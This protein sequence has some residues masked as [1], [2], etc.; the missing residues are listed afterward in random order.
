MAIEQRQW[1]G[2]IFAEVVRAFKKEFEGGG[3]LVATASAA[4]EAFL[5]SKNQTFDVAFLDIK[6]PDT[7][8]AK[9]LTSLNET[10]SP[11]EIMVLTGHNSIDAAIGCA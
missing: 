9:L 2:S 5:V 3:F 6:L 8:R 7:D 4:K 10:E 11:L 1:G